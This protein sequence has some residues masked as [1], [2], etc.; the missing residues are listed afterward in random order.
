[1]VESKVETGETMEKKSTHKVE[2]MPL[3]RE[4]HPNADLLSIIRVYGYT[5]VI[6]NNDWAG[7]DQ[8]AWVPPD[9]LVP[10]S[11]PEF[12]WLK[13]T[14]NTFYNADCVKI[15]PAL[16]PDEPYV[17][18][19]VRRFRKVLS[20]GLFARAP[21]GAKI[22]DDVAELMGVKH[23]NPPEPTDTKGEVASAPNVFALKYDVDSFQ[24]YAQSIFVAGEEVVA[25]EK[26]HGANGRWVFH[27]G[28][29]HCGS[30][31]EWKREFP[32]GGG[33][34]NL[35]WKALRSCPALMEWLQKNPDHLVYGEVY[36]QVQNLKYGTKAG[37]V[38]IGV[39][40]IMKT[41]EF[42][43]NDVAREMAPEL[44]WV[45]I[46]G[47][48]PFD[49]DKLVAL[50]EGPSLIPGA[51]HFREG[52]VVKPVKERAADEVGRVQLKIVSPSYLEKC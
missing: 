17:R 2:V 4:T 16:S 24:R 29:F 32:T 39:F 45:P 8:A 36:G 33:S 6:N 10:V 42:I 27:N 11:R 1:V 21:E 9:S 3:I 14:T 47:R 13:N 5:V 25:T 52:I 49:F 30:R 7:T 22:G 41:G 34:Q 20:Y 28:E 31:T 19:T 15:D 40:D 48:M 23:Y 51:G 35:W 37:E 46:V 43:D 44:P 18:V 12:A 38:R 50:A 26:L